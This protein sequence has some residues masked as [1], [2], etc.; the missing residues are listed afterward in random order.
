MKRRH[1]R[2]PIWRKME[3]GRKKRKHLLYQLYHVISWRKAKAPKEENE[4][5]KTCLYHENS[6]K[7]CR[8][9]QYQLYVDNLQKSLMR[10]ILCVVWKISGAAKRRK[11][12]NVAIFL[13]NG[14]ISFKQKIYWSISKK[15]R[16]SLYISIVKG[17]ACIS[18][19]II[20]TWKTS[21]RLEEEGIFLQ[22]VQAEGEKAE[23]EKL[24]RRTSG[25]RR[26]WHQACCMSIPLLP[27]RKA[28]FTLYLSAAAH[29]YF[30]AF[31]YLPIC[32]ALL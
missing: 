7:I 5:K 23:K 15:K 21:E 9:K 24:K 10:K 19:K 1:R 26:S 28:A 13:F 25:R 29:T 16:K 32:H 22:P 3:E 12:H 30:S 17:M 11:N 31:L 18:L 8:G 4:E 6:Q 2:K 14:G 27:E 20:K